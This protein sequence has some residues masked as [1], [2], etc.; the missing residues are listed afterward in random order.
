MR[1]LIKDIKYSLRSLWK[2]P[3][4]TIIA[5]ITLGLGIGVNTAIL[6]TVNGFIL[7]PLPVPNAHELVVPFWGSKKDPDVWGNFSYANYKDLRE[8]NQSLSGLIAWGMM[9]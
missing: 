6:S 8:Q 5:V 9:S 4:F 3:G 2:H 7:R 1:T